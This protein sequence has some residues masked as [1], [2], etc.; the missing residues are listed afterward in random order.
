MAHRE[1]GGNEVLEEALAELP[2]HGVQACQHD[3]SQGGGCLMEGPSLR[4]PLHVQSL[5][6]IKHQSRALRGGPLGGSRSQSR[7][8]QQ[9]GRSGITFHRHSGLCP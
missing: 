2:V 8:P 9:P 4:A 1:L 7:L 6:Y 3:M 5:E